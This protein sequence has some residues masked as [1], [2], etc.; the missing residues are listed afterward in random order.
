MAKARLISSDIWADEWF[1]ELGYFEQALWI[2]LFSKCADDQGRFLDNALLVRASVFPYKDVVADDIEH[3]LAMFEQA[4]KLHRYEADAKQLCQLVNWW[5]HQHPQWIQPSQFLAP[6]N[7]GDV[8]RMML[9]KKHV[10]VNWRDKSHRGFQV[11]AP[12]EDSRWTLQVVG[13]DYVYVQVYVQDQ[14]EEEVQPAAAAGAFPFALLDSAGVIITG[15]LMA[16]EYTSLW[17]DCNHNRELIESAI[18][19][20][21]STGVRPSA[22]WLR[23][24]VERCLRDECQPGQFKDKAGRKDKSSA[25]KSKWVQ[26]EHGISR[27]VAI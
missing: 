15:S 12:G 19:E 23:A 11:D 25:R 20:A 1:G 27:E 7:W 6:E 22:K 3:A 17:D 5:D 24:V 14:V 4:G 9:N 8:V 26:D 10:E 16:E 18:G 2:G 13:Q 21:A